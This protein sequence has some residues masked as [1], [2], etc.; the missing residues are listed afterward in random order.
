MTRLLLLLALGLGSGG[1]ARAD[2]PLARPL[3]QEE[4]LAAL[5]REIQSHFSLEGDLAIELV[6]PW[7]TPARVAR[8]WQVTVTEFPTVAASSMLLRCRLTADGQPAGDATVVLRASLQRDVWAARQPLTTGALFDAGLLEVR[9]LDLF[10]ERDALPA[11]V[12]DGS[13]V[14]SRSVGA[15]RVLTWRDVARR[16]LVRKGALVEVSATDGRMVLTLKAVALQNG[17]QGEAVTVRNPDSKKDFTAFVID[18][19]R[20]QVRF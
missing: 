11:T 16:P 10:R 14:F 5:A 4:F 9:R 2:E 7:N 3:A 15:G 13:F 20:V 18:E 8:D 12:G 6:R 19:N 17:A 1:A